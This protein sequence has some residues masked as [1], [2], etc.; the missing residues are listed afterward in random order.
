MPKKPKQKCH[1]TIVREAL[2]LSQSEFARR[3]GVSA[4]AIKKAEEGIRPMSNDLISRVYAETGVLFVNNLPVKNFAYT[5]ADHAAWTEEVL[6]NEKSAAVAARVVLKLVELMLVAAARPGVHKSYQVFNALIQAAERVKNEFHLE[7][8]IDAELRDRNA[9]ETKL[10]SVG[11]LRA[12]ALLARMVNFK[13]DPKLKDDATLPLTKSTGWLPGKEIF[14]IWW[15][16][17]EMILEVIKSQG[18]EMTD[19]AKAKLQ[20]MQKQMEQEM[21]KFLPPGSLV[22]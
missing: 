4:S 11:E 6:L 15:Q 16:H 5:E 14:N 18:D 3:L 2:D 17:R 7:K 22:K 12:N 9:T 8:H 13:D 19:E 1:L 20:E 21:E 10:Y